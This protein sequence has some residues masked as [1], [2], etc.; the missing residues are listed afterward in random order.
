GELPGDGR[1]D[2]VRPSCPRQISANKS[3][4]VSE[5]RAKMSWTIHPS[6]LFSLV[7]LYVAYLLL[8]GPLRRR[9]HTPDQIWKEPVESREVFFFSLGVLALLIAEVSPLH[10]L[11]EDYLF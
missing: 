9:F 3:I 1:L 6:V 7:A 5:T 8:I 11:S 10:D 4:E 2:K